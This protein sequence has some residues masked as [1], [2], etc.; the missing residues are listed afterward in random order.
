MCMSFRR[1]A[2]AIEKEF[3]RS[4]LKSSL[5][6][7]EREKIAKSLLHVVRTSND[8]K[9]QYIKS[10]HDHYDHALLKIR[11]NGYIKLSLSNSSDIASSIQRL[12]SAQDVDS[13]FNSSKSQAIYLSGVEK[14]EPVKKLLTDQ[15]LHELV[16]LYLG[17]PASLY[18][19]LAWWQYP[20]D[21]DCKP[22]N[23]QL[24]HRDRDDFSFLKFFM[25]CT[26]VDLSS[27]PHAFLPKTHLSSSL[28]SLFSSDVSNNPLVNGSTHHFLSDF[29]LQNLGYAGQKKVWVGPAGTCFLEDTRGFHRAYVPTMKP[30]LIFSLVWTVGPGFEP[31]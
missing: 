11:E 6:L 12:S 21:S 15:S 19:T 7:S 23:A 1:E 24:W 3:Y 22:S 8:D 13:E 30:R 5:S 25:Y 14:L 31:L 10:K 17:A 20:T 28:P 4:L 26:D 2:M 27:G 9:W 16:S 18:K 29:D